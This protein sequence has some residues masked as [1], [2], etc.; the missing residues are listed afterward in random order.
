MDDTVSKYS[1]TVSKTPQQDDIEMYFR[2]WQSQIL[3]SKI[4]GRLT[5]IFLYDVQKIVTIEEERTQEKYLQILWVRQ[6]VWSTCFSTSVTSKTQYW[7][8]SFYWMQKSQM[9]NVELSDENSRAFVAHLTESLLVIV[10]SNWSYFEESAIQGIGVF[11]SHQRFLTQ[12]LQDPTQRNELHRNMT[13][14]L[15]KKS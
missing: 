2:N 6:I 10:E 13:K 8:S 7:S 4:F 15:A 9:M 3:N 12:C 11:S 5:I 14:Y 1:F